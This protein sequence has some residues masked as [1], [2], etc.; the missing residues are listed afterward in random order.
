MIPDGSTGDG[1]EVFGAN[2]R[3][4]MMMMMMMMK[5]GNLK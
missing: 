1:V 4:R 2:M 5:E 3:M